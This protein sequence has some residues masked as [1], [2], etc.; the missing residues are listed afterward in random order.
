MNSTDMESVDSSESE[1]EK[2]YIPDQEELD[3]DSMVEDEDS[4]QVYDDVN[5]QDE[6]TGNIS[7]DM[8]ESNS[9]GLPTGPT[10]EGMGDEIQGVGDHKIEDEEQDDHNLTD[11]EVNYDENPEVVDH[12]SEGVGGDGHDAHIDGVKDENQDNLSTVSE[13]VENVTGDQESGEEN[14]VQGTPRY[15]LR[16]N[17][18]RSYKH[19]YNPKLYEMEHEKQSDL[20]DVVLTTQLTTHWRTRHRCQ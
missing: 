4:G 7:I 10:Q 18:T 3:E 8:S 2:D 13:S 12:E 6:L 16:K 9:V 1:D 15:D 19:V 5:E 14:G 20:G 11:L 17:C